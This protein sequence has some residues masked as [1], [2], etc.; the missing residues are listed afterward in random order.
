MKIW[1]YISI[2][3]ELPEDISNKIDGEKLFLITYSINPRYKLS[4]K[5]KRINIMLP[6]INLDKHFIYYEVKLLNEVINMV[7]DK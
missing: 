7:K 1:K 5:L 2:T 4:Y 6:L 3:I